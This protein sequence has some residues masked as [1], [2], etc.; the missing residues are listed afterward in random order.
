MRKRTTKEAKGRPGD[1]MN[2]SRGG[3]RPSARIV[4]FEAPELD[5][6]YAEIENPKQSAI[7]R[8][9]EAVKS[10]KA[11]ID[12]AILFCGRFN[13]DGRLLREAKRNAKP[14]KILHTRSH[15]EYREAMSRSKERFAGLPGKIKESARRREAMQKVRKALRENFVSNSDLGSNMS[16]DPNQFTEYTPY[17]SGPFYKQQYM[18]YFKGHARAFQEWTHNPIAKRIVDLLVQYALGRGFQVKCKNKKLEKSWNAFQAKNKIQFKI[19]KF[20]GREYLIY[21]ENFIDVLRWVSVDPS[22]IWDIIC[23]GYDEYIDDVLYY[24]QMFQCLRGDTRIALLDGTTPT[25]KELAERNKPYWVYSYDHKTGR[26][27]PGLAV[28]TWAQGKKRCVKVTLDSGES[29]VC[30]FDHPFLSR[31]GEY[32]W[33]ENLKPGDSLMPLYRKFGYE[34]VW[35][36]KTGW[37]LTHHMVEGKPEKGH[38]VHHKN[39]CLT[40][41]RPDNLETLT[42]NEHLKHHTSRLCMAESS[43]CFQRS[44][45]WRKAIAEAS[46]KRWANNPDERKAISERTKAQWANPETRKRMSDGI[47]LSKNRKQLEADALKSSVVVNHKVLKVEPAGDELVYDLTVDKHHNFALACG[48]FTHNTATQTYTGMDVKGVEGSKQSTIGHYIVRQI[49]FDQIIHIKTNVTSGEKRGRSVYYSILG[50]LK[51]L[52]DLYNSQVLGEQLRAS[53]VWDDTIQGDSQDVAAHAAKYSYIPVAPS[54]F[55]HNEA[56]TRKPLAPMAGVTGGAGGDIGNQILALIATSQGFPKDHLNVTS[57]GGSRATAIVGSEPFTKVIE[58]LQEDFSDLLDRIIE[59]FCGQAGADYNHE[60][61][62]KIFPSV[63]KDTLADVLKNLAMREGMGWISK[64]QA[65]TQAAA[66]C[67]DDEYDY[68]KMVKEQA[69]DTAAND[70]L[71]LHTPKP[72]PAGR[73]GMQP[74]PG[75]DPLAGGEDTENPLHGSGKAAIKKQ[76]KNL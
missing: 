14:Y 42:H 47:S 44:P 62:K 29:V 26:I 23:E 43:K 30:S 5:E 75:E 66:E 25:I 2:S 51:R 61:W 16:L 18:D 28:K 37:E 52:V 53:F 54:I 10:G 56:I 36:P 35:Q 13:Q 73:F 21:G 50:W 74:K 11:V 6:V 8:V 64:R 1:W 48:V 41:N 69:A 45:A 27:V 70:P 71:N 67:D 15:R 46:K 63:A 65:A 57:A 49:P 60:D 59:K 33:A 17:F 39:K 31:K 9:M 68:D 7:G 4:A 58:D 12:D 32:V 22:T 55:V 20:W 76:H 38:A 34:R 24:Q 40:D 19:R 3:H 72:P